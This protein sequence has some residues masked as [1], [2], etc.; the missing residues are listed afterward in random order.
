MLVIWLA[1][2]F[3]LTTPGFQ[4][5]ELLPWVESLGLSYRLGLDGL[6]LPL[7]A[8]NS[9]LTIV[10]VYISDPKLHRP[11]AVLRSAAGNQQCRRRSVSVLESAAVL[12]LLRAGAGSPLPA[13]CH[14]GRGETRFMPRLN[15]LIYT[16]LSGVLI[17]GAFLGLVWLS[18]NSSFDYDSNLAATLP[19]VQ[20]VILLIAL[21]V[22]FGIKIPLF[23]F[24]TW[25][26]DAPRGGPPLP[27][28]CCWPGAAEAGHLRAG[29]VSAWGCSPDAW[30]ALA[31]W[32]G[33]DGRVIQR[34]PNG[35][36]APIS[37]AGYEEDGGLQ[38]HWPHGL[39]CCWRGG[40]SNSP[41]HCRHRV[42]DG[43]ATG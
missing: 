31:P 33:R 14:L 1:S 32:G 3:E 13:D 16:A 40:G 9:L 39:W 20:Q 15:F 30:M 23:P 26:P 18:G 25:L 10:A 7:L 34:S 27:F 28:R 42:P 37:T 17:L 24:H 5:E 11:P 41:Q 21:L 22:G 38:L 36:L 6:S 19:L 4:F 35:S 43:G 2:Q 29:A 12:H 8:I